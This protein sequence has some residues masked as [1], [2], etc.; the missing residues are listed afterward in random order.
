LGG[1]GSVD[2]R[3]YCPFNDAVACQPVTFFMQKSAG[4]GI[5]IDPLLLKS[6]KNKK[7]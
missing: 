5:V 1:V 2:E 3:K 7:L 4:M 6:S